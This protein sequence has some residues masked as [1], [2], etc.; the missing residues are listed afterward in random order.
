[1]HGRTY[2]A[3][4]DLDAMKSILRQG[5]RVSPRSGYWHPGELDWWFF[6]RQREWDVTVWEDDSGP[7]GWIVLDPG[8]RSA[9]MAIRPDLRGGPSEERLIAHVDEVL[10]RGPVTL[11]AWAD[12]EAR[13]T[14]LARH[15]FGREGPAFQTFSFALADPIAVPSLP[16]GFGLL[17]AVTEQWV[18]ERAECHHRAFD[19]SAMTAD[20][21]ASFRAAPDY[22]RGLDVAVAS[23]DGRIVAFAMAWFDPESRTG[24]LEPV[25]T[26]PHFW[27]RG[28][29]RAANREA[30]R[31]LSSRGAVVACVNTYA[32]HE[33]NLA[34]Y[35]SCGFE[36]G[37]TI[38]RW[39]RP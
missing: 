20:L 9:D 11:F 33:G 19:P 17:D 24:Q 14:I 31:R 37:T 23:D 3:G 26:R 12:D 35:E 32:G 4:D 8:T 22:D 25:G 36:R 6:Y 39:V 30:M 29:G 10:G 5:R 7:A 28:L 34:F 18:A 38:D 27:R 15:G 1:M 2:V 16:E 13:A 21:Y